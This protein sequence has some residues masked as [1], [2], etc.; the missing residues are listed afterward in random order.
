M[1]SEAPAPLNEGTLA[2]TPLAHVLLHVGLRQL[3]GTLALWP[4]DPTER[5]G[6]DRILFEGGIAVRMRPIEAVANLDRGLGALFARQRAPYAL[7]EADLVGVGQRVVE[8]RVDPFALVAR[9]LRGPAARIHADAM[10]RVLER[11]GATPVRLRDTAILTRFALEDD[12]RAVV[13]GLT[14]PITPAALLARWEVPD[15]PRRVLYLLAMTRSLEATAD[16]GASRAPSHG[17]SAGTSLPPLASRFPLASSTP[18]QP[19]EGTTSH[20]PSMRRHSGIPSAPPPP[21]PPP[22]GLSPELEHRWSEIVERAQAIEGQTYFDMLAVGRTDG[23]DAVREAYFEQVRRWHP[24]RLPPDLQPLAPWVDRIFHHVTEA[25]DTLSD[26]ER[27]KQYARA[28]REGG[29]TPDADRR[30]GAIVGAALEFQK[31]EVMARRRSWDEAL[32]IL[33]DALALN[34]DEADFHAMHAWLLFQKH[35]MSGGAPVADMRASVDRALQLDEQCVRALYTK[36]VILKQLGH[37]DDALEH[38]R[39]ATELDPRHLEAAR[40]VR[41]AEMRQRSSGRVPSEGGRPS[42]LDRFF[43]GGGKKK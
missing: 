18:A 1:P 26:P 29:G 5:P 36:G 20:P 9:A 31:V 27:R 35:G 13:Q 43:G 11:L 40:E 6:Q 12:E 14:Q 24:D 30:L 15:V 34:P 28:V 4:D 41:L 39:R 22:D 21:P 8:G 37:G 2:R 19:A 33:A 23:E 32:Q 7:Y 16:A 38:F 25:R 10:E 42:L 17:A 3:D